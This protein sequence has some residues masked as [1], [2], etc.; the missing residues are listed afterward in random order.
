MIRASRLPPRH[1]NSCDIPV[2]KKSAA[3]TAW[4]KEFDACEEARASLLARYEV[5]KASKP[6]TAE[7]A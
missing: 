7:I 5:L 6:K 4:L 2:P 3:V 1:A